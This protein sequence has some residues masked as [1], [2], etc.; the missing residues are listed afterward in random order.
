MYQDFGVGR[1]QIW[2]ESLKCEGS[3]VSISDCRHDGWGQHNCKHS[4]DVSVSCVKEPG[5][6][7]FTL[8]NCESNSEFFSLMFIVAR[9]E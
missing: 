2:L 3:E 5:K 8:T 1:G 4:E 7:P 6:G 9:Y